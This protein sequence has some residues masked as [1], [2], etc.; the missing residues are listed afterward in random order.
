[1]EP[2]IQSEQPSASDKGP[3]VR[4]D[5]AGL[6]AIAS[7]LEDR[8]EA[9]R[10][11]GP[12]PPTAAEIDRADQAMRAEQ[13]EHAATERNMRRATV[14]DALEE[15]RAKQGLKPAEAKSSAELLALLRAQ[16]EKEAGQQAIDEDMR[17]RAAHAQAAQ[18]EQQQQAQQQREAAEQERLAAQVQEANHRQ[19]QQSAGLSAFANRL[20]SEANAAFPDFKTMEDYHRIRM[21]NPARFQEFER[22]RGILVSALTDIKNY[23]QAQQQQARQQMNAYSTQEDAKFTAQH[24]EMSDPVMAAEAARNT[25]AA[26][27]EFGDTQGDLAFAWKNDPIMADHRVPAMLLE[28]GKWHT[29]KQT[30]RDKL[31][32]TKPPVQRPGASMGRMSVDHSEVAQAERA[33]EA[34]RDAKTAAA[35]T[36]ARRRA[37]AAQ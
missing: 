23:E 18:I 4:S 25:A 12:P 7:E 29:A 37:A 5:A 13:D 15:H 6:R 22:A 10:N 1:M 35:L 2:A 36:A 32:N 24:P 20:V 30:M 14:F 11:D 34:K 17:A 26:L 28:L 27:E 33:F 16:E 9:E 3:P 19:A 21:E 31:V 8:R